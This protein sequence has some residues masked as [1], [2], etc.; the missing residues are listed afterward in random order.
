MQKDERILY[1]YTNEILSWL[2]PITNFSLGI[3]CIIY[4]LQ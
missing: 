3:I 1:Y 4:A 2:L